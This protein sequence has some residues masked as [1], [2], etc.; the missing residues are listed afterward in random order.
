MID[1]NSAIPLYNQVA[2]DIRKDILSGK[3]EKSA[4]LGTQADLVKKFDVSLITIRKA[5]QILEKEGLVDIQQGKGTYVKRSNLVDNLEN[6][7]GISNMM[8]HYDIATEIQV[9][10]LE[11]VDTPDWLPEDVTEALGSRC[12][13]IRRVVIVGEKPRAVIEMYLP[14]KY[15]GSFSV[16]EV[17]R[18]TVY[19]VYQNKLGVE[20][21]RGRQRIEASSA[22][23]AVAQCLG[24]PEGAPILLIKRK[25]YSAAGELIEYMLLSYA[26]DAYSFE[27]ELELSKE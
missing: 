6:L 24:V 1:K 3:Y 9:P 26:A 16:E 23:D 10:V 25:A 11:P 17:Q 18:E 4:S 12:L 15:I 2:R 19:R 13:F 14:E 22:K 20:L 21:G 7:T 27:V 5:L 8:A